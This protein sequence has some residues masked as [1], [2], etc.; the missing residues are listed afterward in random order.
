MV[1]S[2]NNKE[3]IIK[4]F[5]PKVKHYALRYYHI[6]QSVLEVND[7]I[8]AGI[9]GLLEALNKYDPS[10]N[11]PLTSFI[12][13]R[14][15]GA[16]LDEIRSM[17]VFSKE[18]RKKVE[19]VKKAYKNFKNLGKEPTDE[20]LAKSLN[21]TYE[22]LQEIY[23][24]IRASEIISFDTLITMQDGDKLSIL[25][26]VSD[27][28]SLFEEISLRQ[29]KERLVVAIDQLSETEKLVISLY[30]YE[31]LNMKEVAEILGVT[32]SRASQIHGKA[33]IKLKSFLE[34]EV[35]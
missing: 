29:L 6:V 20:E 7:L 22:E 25:E 26:V 18:F 4:Q 5:L 19:N 3:K 16:I 14:I 11:V 33:L 30:Y 23:K 28:K 9:K 35:F 2:E 13:Y 12:D 32:L 27:G 34:N 10:K 15:R 17:D 24:S 31:E 8:S 21:I 1:Y